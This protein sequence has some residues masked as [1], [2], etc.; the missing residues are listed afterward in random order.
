MWAAPASVSPMTAE[1]APAL[2]DE[3][4]EICRRTLPP[5]AGAILHGSLATASFV[6]GRSDVDVLAIVDDRPSA[7]ELAALTSAVDALRS[8]AVAADLCVVTRR[9]AAAPT[10]APPADIY[11]RL[12]PAVQGLEV[13]SRQPRRDLVV[14]FSVCRAHGRSLAGP[15]PADLIGDV[16]DEWVMDVGAEVLAMWQRQDYDPDMAAFMVLT[17]CRIWRFAEE[18]VHCSK[19]EAARWALARD[20]SVKVVRSVLEGHPIEEAPVRDFLAYVQSATQGDPP[21]SPG[22][23]G[24]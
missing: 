13:E 9:T 6:P 16:P 4:V 15:A 12:D 11:V 1:R 8:D 5:L 17:T 2:A 3:V 14:D 19:P 24:A 21:R 10:P 23:A 7:D 20:Q 18:R 22:F